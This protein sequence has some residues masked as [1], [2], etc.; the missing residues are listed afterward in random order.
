VQGPLRSQGSSSGEGLD[1]VIRIKAKETQTLFLYIV[2]HYKG[3]NIVPYEISIY[4][5]GSAEF[6][7]DQTVPNRM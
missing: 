4:A 3:V 1:A 5:R 7:L 6:S 2:P